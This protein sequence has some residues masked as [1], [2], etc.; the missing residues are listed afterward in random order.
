[1][2]SVFFHDNP[3]QGTYFKMA[4][5]FTY[6]NVDF[7]KIF[8]GLYPRIPVAGGDDPL[9]ASLHPPLAPPAPRT[10]TPQFPTPQLYNHNY[11]TEM[12]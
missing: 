6:S 1:M 10:Q 2:L 5:K 12:Q 9:R 11:H 3:L 4:R 7:Q 8:R